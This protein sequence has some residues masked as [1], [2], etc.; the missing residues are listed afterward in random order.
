MQQITT[1]HVQ[2]LRSVLLQRGIPVTEADIYAAAANFDDQAVVEEIAGGMQVKRWDKTS[3]INDV[4]AAEVLAAREDIPE[5]GIVYLILE[6]G[7][8][9]YFQPHDPV[10]EGVVA[11][12]EDTWEQVANDH[13][14]RI[15]EAR[16]GERFVASL[17]GDKG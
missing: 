13:L 16:V 8:V 15:V 1:E 2:Y 4:P 10:T 7:R 3:P 17:A 14:K 9:A 11:L 5:E 6:N 12:G